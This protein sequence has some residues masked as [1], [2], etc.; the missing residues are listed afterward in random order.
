MARRE[1]TEGQ[2]GPPEGSLIEVRCACGHLLCKVG[3]GLVEIKHR[4]CPW[5]TVF[6][7]KSGEKLK[8]T[9]A[10]RLQEA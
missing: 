7:P 8:E 10:M 5:T 3:N 1:A 2:A 4:S 9:R 6:D